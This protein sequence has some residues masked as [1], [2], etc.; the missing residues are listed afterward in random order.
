MKTIVAAIFLT[1]IGLHAQTDPYE[2]LWQGYDGEWGHVS[3]Q[4]VALAEAIPP[5][6][7]A[8]RPGPGLRSTSEERGKM[9]AGAQAGAG[10]SGY[11]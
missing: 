11:S 6:K 4:L 8:W 5:E 1:A 3:R 9:T 10:Q 7:F 2:G